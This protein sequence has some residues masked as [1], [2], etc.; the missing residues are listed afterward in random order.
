M[1]VFD[2]K[3]FF[4]VICIFLLIISCSNMKKIKDEN[5][6]YLTIAA[7]NYKDLGVTTLRENR[8]FSQAQYSG[9]IKIVKNKIFINEIKTQLKYLKP[10]KPQKED[11]WNFIHDPWLGLICHLSEKKIN[12]TFSRDG[13]IKL[14]SNFYEYDNNLAEILHNQLPVEIMKTV[15][16]NYPPCNRF[17]ITRKKINELNNYR[18]GIN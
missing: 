9:Y 13:Y 16:K 8:F 4:I 12:L 1:F 10:L 11:F 17:K 15:P 5:I 7:V 2:K 6:D 18:K 14:G 3:R